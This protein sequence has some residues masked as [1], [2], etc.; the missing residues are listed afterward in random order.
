MMDNRDLRR[1]VVDLVDLCLE[2]CDSVVN[3]PPNGMIVREQ[4]VNRLLAKVGHL[5]GT[6]IGR[7]LGGEDCE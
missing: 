2:L 1:E 7:F 3:I 4:K 5:T 6:P